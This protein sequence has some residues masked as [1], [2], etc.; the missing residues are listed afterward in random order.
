MPNKFNRTNFTEQ[1]LIFDVVENDLAR[2]NF[3]YYD[4][5]KPR[6]YYTVREED[7]LRP[8]LISVKSLGK[9]DYWWIICKLNKIDDVFNDMF[10]GQSLQIPSIEDVE[11]YYLETRRKLDLS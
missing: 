3:I 2:N 7:M 10:L 11:N 9:Q 1:N 6:T 8:D 5:K 4:F